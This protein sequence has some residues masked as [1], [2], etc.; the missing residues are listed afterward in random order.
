MTID[1]KQLEESYRIL[2]VEDN[3][4]AA[5]LFQIKL[6]QE[7]YV[8]DLAK[9]GSEGLAM[10]ERNEYDLV[11]LDQNIPDRS[12]LDILQSLTGRRTTPPIIMITAQNDTKT[13]V[14]AM[15]LGASDYV[16]KGLHNEYLQSKKEE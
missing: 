12:G 15:K 8:V 7:G 1:R 6:Q 3:H 5:R 14:E 13:A 10:L 9:S 16:V 4:T 11:A 2:Y